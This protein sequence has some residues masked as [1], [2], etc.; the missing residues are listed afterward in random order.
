MA[1]PQT[2]SFSSDYNECAAAAVLLME[3]ILCKRGCNFSF[4]AYTNDAVTCDSAFV[5]LVL[6]KFLNRECSFSAHMDTNHYE[7]SG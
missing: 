2:K 6:M 5:L 3:S 7:K 1:Q 4:L